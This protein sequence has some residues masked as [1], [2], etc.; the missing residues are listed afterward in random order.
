MTC[1]KF[2]QDW[3]A[4]LAVAAAADSERFG[5]CCSHNLG[6]CQHQADNLYMLRGDL[7]AT[8]ISPPTPISK[9][10]KNVTKL[11]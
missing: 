10:I 7:V 11:D 8:L 5:H 4:T 1:K 2:A 6:C 9:Q 3:L